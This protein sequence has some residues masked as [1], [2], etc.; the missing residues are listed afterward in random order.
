MA[1]FRS[2]RIDDDEEDFEAYNARV[3]RMR[4]KH[5]NQ[6]DIYKVVLCAAIAIIVL[7]LGH[8]LLYPYIIQGVAYSQ[9]FLKGMLKEYRRYKKATGRKNSW[10]SFFCSI[11][12]PISIPLV[13]YRFFK[14]V[15]DKKISLLF[16]LLMVLPALC[17]DIT[18]MIVLF[19]FCRRIVSWNK[20]ALCHVMICLS[21]WEL[22]IQNI[23]SVLA[24]ALLSCWYLN[25]KNESSGESSGESSVESYASMIAP[26]LEQAWSS[27]RKTVGSWDVENFVWDFAWV[28]REQM[29]LGK[30]PVVY[31]TMTG[32]LGYRRRGDQRGPS[33][34]F[35]ARDRSPHRR[36]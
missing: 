22:P 3:S 18:T 35:S 26:C 30:R 16:P 28:L 33:P 11:S 4:S 34:P 24:Q 25:R 36:Q 27:V 29:G 20:S 17:A 19:A 13:A 10:L 9:G 23:W 2:L 14:Q 21:M 12:K 31:N 5:R 32:T 7:L 15:I 8:Y 1:R 6:N